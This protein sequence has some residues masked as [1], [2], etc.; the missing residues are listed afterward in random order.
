MQHKQNTIRLIIVQLFTASGWSGPTRQCLRENEQLQ[1]E[2]PYSVPSV[3]SWKGLCT[4]MG[5][6]L[7]ELKSGAPSRWWSTRIAYWVWLYNL[8]PLIMQR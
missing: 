4:G 8:P 1:R 2:S 3:E 7:P 6:T 5:D